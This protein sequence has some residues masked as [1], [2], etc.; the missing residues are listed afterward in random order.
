MLIR[1]CDRKGC[2]KTY[3]PYEV[4]IKTGNQA[5]SPIQAA[6]NTLRKLC[7][8]IGIAEPPHGANSIELLYNGERIEDTRSHY[9]LCPEC[10]GQIV[11]FLRGKAELEGDTDETDP[12]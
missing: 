2:G 1:K 9:D 7:E 12:T 5:V 3:E 10:M 8:E 6:A 4:S 11:A